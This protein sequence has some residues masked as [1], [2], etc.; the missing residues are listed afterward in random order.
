M[1]LEGHNAV[2]GPVDG[3]RPAETDLERPQ[4]NA[5]ELD[6]FGRYSQQ[7]PLAVVVHGIKIFAERHQIVI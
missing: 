5:F 7:A 6:R 3:L 4:V 1:G 2:T